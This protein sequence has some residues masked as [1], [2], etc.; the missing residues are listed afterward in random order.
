M[1]I[2]VDAY[3]AIFTSG[4]I[5][6]YARGLISALTEINTTD[7]LILFYNRFRERGKAWR[8]E[9]GILR[10]RQLYFPRRL[11]QGTWN[12][13]NWPPIELFCGSVDI[14]HGLHFV[15]P[16]VQ[17]A[18]RVLTVHDLTYLKYPSYFTNRKLNERGY[19]QELPRGLD[20]ADAVIAVSQKTREDL[21]EIMGFPEKRVRV[22][23]E[24]VDHHFFVK[25]EGQKV[26]AIQ[27]LYGLSRPYL[28]FLVGTPEPRKNI[29]RTVEAVRKASPQLDLA[30][31]G[32]RG[33]LREL[34][35]NNFRNLIFTGFVPEEHLPAL[36][37]GATIS[38]YPSLYEGFGLPVLESMACGVPVI[39]SNRGSLPEVAG[40]A[41][42][43]VDPEDEDSI[44]GAISELL[45]NEVL[46]NRL[47]ILGKKRASEFTWKKTAAQTLSL[48]RELV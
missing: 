41:A 44:A 38:L 17:K 1:K 15:L 5:A 45:R 18:R 27:K 29:T 40:G 46:Q 33:P 11:L 13:I 30:L 12:F 2:V 19:R 24:G 21:I 25:A 42:I 26:A 34:L 35:G 16:P 43:L 48:Y 36:L 22:I 23:Y 28:I 39:T 4:G 8:N 31:I 20:K 6:R 9:R 10:V 32:P 47:K 14:F 7:E 37:S 3:H